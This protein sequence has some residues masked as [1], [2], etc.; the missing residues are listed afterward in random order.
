VKILVTGSQGVLG[1]P[2][3]RELQ[4]RGHE[5]V[6]ADLFHMPGDLRTDV[7]EARQVERTFAEVRPEACYHLAAEFGRVNGQHYYEQ[8]WK[9]NCLGTRN[10][11]ESCIKHNTRLIFASSSGAYGSLADA[12]A[13]QETDLD[14]QVPGYDNE[15]FL[16]KWTNEQQIRTAIRNSSLNA[17]ILRFFNIYGP[18]ERYSDYRSVICLFIYRSM[19]RL[20]VTVYT[21]THRS[22]LYVD[23]WTQAVVNVAD[24]PVGNGE[25]F[26]IGSKMS[27]STLDLYNM[28]VMAVGS[29]GPVQLVTK[30]KTNIADKAP[31]CRKA[32]QVLGL[33][34]LV[35][36]EEGIERTVAW[37]RRE[38]A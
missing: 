31:D 5:V 22:Y 1:K 20:P 25:A 37:M 17:T 13:L 24:I 6:G 14:T 18:G 32:E 4:S 15:Y 36:L 28:I 10:V 16:T 26:N 2:L 34:E 27:V 7:S 9:T 33:K 19:K 35:S 8:L 21:G 11:I 12:G 3:V 30:E 23:D 29:S 38:Y